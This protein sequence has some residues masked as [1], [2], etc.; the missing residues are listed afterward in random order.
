MQLAAAS[1]EVILIVDA[2]VAGGNRERGIERHEW[3]LRLRV[4]AG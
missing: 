3:D 1:G 2:L 4:N